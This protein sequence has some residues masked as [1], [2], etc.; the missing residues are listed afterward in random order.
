MATDITEPYWDNWDSRVIMVDEHNQAA[1]DL[2]EMIRD[3]INNYIYDYSRKIKELNA[4][5]PKD[6][7]LFPVCVRPRDPELLIKARAPFFK[8]FQMG[9]TSPTSWGCKRFACPEPG[10]KF[11]A[12]T[13]LQVRDDCEPLRNY[14][15]NLPRE[16]AHTLSSDSSMLPLIS[17]IRG[18]SVWNNALV[19]INLMAKK[20][21][22]SDDLV[23]I[24]AC[25]EFRWYKIT[26]DKKLKTS[27]DSPFGVF[28]MEYMFIKHGIEA[29]VE[30]DIPEELIGD[31]VLIVARSTGFQDELIVYDAVVEEDIRKISTVIV[32][33]RGGGLHFG[34][35]ATGARVSAGYINF[36]V[37]KF[38]SHEENLFILKEAQSAM[39]QY[40]PH[41]VLVVDSHLPQESLKLPQKKGNILALRR[42]PNDPGVLSVPFKVTFSTMGYYNNG[43]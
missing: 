17:P 39:L 28:E 40:D 27:I 43:S 3:Q 36:K 41:D 29:L 20:N 8:Q 18:M 12:S 16:K 32:A 21:D 35:L 15:F 5:L 7:K 11:K 30:V 34:F 1:Y 10:E 19:E 4:K 31:H 33:S 24:D 42:G 26:R 25:I 23:L 37:K 2:V 6:Q 22:K 38:G 9:N 13:M 14:I